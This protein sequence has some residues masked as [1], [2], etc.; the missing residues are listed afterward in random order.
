MTPT[1]SV[2]TLTATPTDQLSSSST[3][4]PIPSNSMGG[5]QGEGLADGIGKGGERGRVAG[6]HY[7]QLAFLVSTLI[8]MWLDTRMC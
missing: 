2:A 8:L 4:T 5:T 6:V 1:T 7:Y 3:A